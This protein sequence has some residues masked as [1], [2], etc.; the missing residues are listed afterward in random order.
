MN[1]IVTT[2]LIVLSAGTAIHTALASEEAP[3]AA[4][5]RD[6][7]AALYQS[8]TATIVVTGMRLDENPDNYTKDL[9]VAEGAT[10]K[11]TAQDGAARQKKTEAFTRRGKKGGSPEEYYTAD[12]SVDLGT[13]YTIAM[14]FKD[15]TAVEVKDYAIPRDWK[16]HFYFHSTNGTKSPASILRFVEDP[17]TKLR[18]CVYAVYPLESYRKLGGRQMP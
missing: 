15:G 9:S 3:R 8:N 17:K 14:T 16:T 12:F 7:N 1:R 4:S 2:V 18:C 11:V 5:G 13:T 6:R 10:V